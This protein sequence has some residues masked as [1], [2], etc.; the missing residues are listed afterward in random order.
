MIPAPF[1][2]THRSPNRS[3]RQA[4]ARR[5]V[6]L[7]HAAMTDLDGLR[8]LEM[9]AKELSSTAIVKDD[10]C[11]LLVPDDG[12]R[13]WSLA[14]AW[15]D[16]AFRSVETC[17]ESTVGYTVS[18]ASHWTLARVVAYWAQRD[19][20]YPHRSGDRSTW[21]VIGHR[22]FHDIYERSYPTACP[23][24]LDLDLVTRRAQQLL[25]DDTATP[26]ATIGDIHM[27]Q[28][29]YFARIDDL[30][31]D[32]GEWMIAGV[33]LFVDPTNDPAVTKWHTRDGFWVTTDKEVARVWAR[34]YGIGPNET[35]AVRLKRA[36]YMAQQAYATADAL[37]WRAG[38]RA[39][40]A[41]A[42]AA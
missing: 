36:P 14:D 28:R 12:D 33:D 27:S 20:F 29:Q 38:I 26:P 2:A 16:S 25:A 8:R 34:Q 15:G 35:R 7:H 40:L 41:P 32:D 1:T 24:A 18:D 11:E 42:S 9:G 39:L 21:T 30:E 3:T 13:P 5:G 37:A 17:N 4:V 19:G 31:R 6:V 10:A 22:E 23:G